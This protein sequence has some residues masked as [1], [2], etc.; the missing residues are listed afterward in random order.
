MPDTTTTSNNLDTYESD[1]VK[2]LSHMEPTQPNL[3]LPG[4]L[5]WD[6]GDSKGQYSLDCRYRI[7]SVK[8][9]LPTMNWKEDRALGKYLLESVDFQNLVTIEW[10]E[11]VYRSMQK[12]HFDWFN[13][14]YDRIN[15]CFVV[16]A[17]GKLRSLSLSL[18]HFT[19][20]NA[21]NPVF[22]TPTAEEI[23]TI[24]FKSL[25]PKTFGAFE[26]S[27]AADNV[28]EILS[29]TYIVQNIAI[30]YSGVTS[31]ESAADSKAEIICKALGVATTDEVN[32]LQ[33]TLF[34]KAGTNEGYLT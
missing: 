32:P 3:F 24:T 25:R 19:T 21:S 15:N 7:Q 17:K 13:E 16:G 29:C 34:Y 2:F 4:T 18:Y 5:A 8:F 14:W 9:D 6:A 26:L 27:Q 22:N 12:Y 30:E 23:A 1:M 33:R 31:S 11:D 10:R 20:S 28:G